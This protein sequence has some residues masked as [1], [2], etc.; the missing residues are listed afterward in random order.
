MILRT[1]SG[2]TGLLML[3][4][5]LDPAW[6]DAFRRW[7][8]EDMFPARLAIGFNACASYDRIDA[9]TGAARYLTLYETPALGDLY[10]AAYQGLRSNRDVRDA[11]FHARFRDLDRSTLAWVGPEFAR[12]NGA[13]GTPTCASFAPFVAVRRFALPA[14]SVARFNQWYVDA[15][16]PACAAITGIARVRR[17][18]TVEAAGA[19]DAAH[20]LLHEFTQQSVRDDPRWHDLACAPA[21]SWTVPDGSAGALYRRV[22]SQA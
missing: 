9:A 20:V 10:G 16:L 11:A 6:H 5:N 2:G 13:A 21:W 14:D 19:P 8:V 1:P 3:F 17:Y 4:C 7:L 15:Y 12:S 22:V 18:V